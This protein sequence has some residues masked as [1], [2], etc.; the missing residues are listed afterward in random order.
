MTL[1]HLHDGAAVDEKPQDR[2]ARGAHVARKEVVHD[3]AQEERDLW[4]NGANPSVGNADAQQILAEQAAGV[5]TSCTSATTCSTQPY[6]WL[7]AH[8]SKI[9]SEDGHARQGQGQGQ[10]QG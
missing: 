5:R 10:S 8:S 3:A 9:A 6:A 4:G 1:S 7:R 2:G